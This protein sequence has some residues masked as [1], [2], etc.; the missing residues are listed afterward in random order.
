MPP[1]SRKKCDDPHDDEYI[2]LTNQFQIVFNKKCYCSKEWNIAHLIWI[3][4]IIDRWL[5]VLTT[6]T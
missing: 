6:P 5:P 2:S 4:W 1:I 3:I